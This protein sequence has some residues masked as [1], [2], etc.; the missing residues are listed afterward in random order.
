MPSE[1]PPSNDVAL[2]VSDLAASLKRTV[3][4]NYDHVVVRGELGRVTIARSGHMYC[5]LKDERAVLNTVMWKG[6]V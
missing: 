4:T 3:E 5:D 1:S 2:S 6:Q